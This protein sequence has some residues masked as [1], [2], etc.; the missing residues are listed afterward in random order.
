M[1]K[2]KP[3]PQATKPMKNQTLRDNLDRAKKR[4]RNAV[5]LYVHD[6]VVTGWREDAIVLSRTLG[7][8]PWQ[9]NRGRDK[10]VKQAS[11]PLA[12]LDRNVALLQKQGVK[13]VVL[14]GTPVPP[15]GKRG[16]AKGDPRLT[17]EVPLDVAE[18]ERAKA[19]VRSRWSKRE[20]L[21]RMGANAPVPVVFQESKFVF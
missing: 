5:L 1:T 14:Y 7:L 20:E 10:G 12:V 19:R 17:V 15:R 9:S 21:H 13:V 4:Y 16:R 18:V 6:G 8:L 2:Q 11:F 3:I